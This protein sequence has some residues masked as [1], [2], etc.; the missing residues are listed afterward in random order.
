FASD[1]YAVGMSAIA[2]LTGIQPHELEEDT[3]TGEV[4]WLE[5]V[6]VSQ[7]LAEVITKMVRR[8]YSLRYSSAKDV[9]EALNSQ[10]QSAP[11]THINPPKPQSSQQ[12]KTT[13]PVSRLQTVSFSR[14]KTLQI[15]GF[16]GGG[17]TAVILG[18]MWG[19]ASPSSK[20]Q[21]SSTSEKPTTSSP[22]KSNNSNKQSF[23]T[24]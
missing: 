17:F 1:V 20:T 21:S 3:R 12:S 19:S 4:I 16:A 9:L 2:A 23:S 22:G 14:R 11:A 10:A 18:R 8:H 15:L 13:T 6:R 24:P 7:D 5:K